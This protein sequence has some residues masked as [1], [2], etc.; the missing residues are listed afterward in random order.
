[1]LLQ[2][3][4]SFKQAFTSLKASKLRALLTML[5]IIIGVASVIIMLTTGNGAKGLI[6]SEIEDLGSNLIFVIAGGEGSNQVDSTSVNTFKNSDVDVLARKSGSNPLINVA[7]F[8]AMYR[9]Q[10]Q[11]DKRDEVGINVQGIDSVYFSM[12]NLNFE[13][14]KVWDAEED[15]AV[16]RLAVLGSKARDKIFG[17]GAQNLVGKKVKLG[18]Q[19]F[20]IVG[21]LEEK[22]SALGSLF[23]DDNAENVFVP[24]RT[25]QKVLLGTDDFVWGVYSQ[26][27]DKY[28]VEKA[29]VFIEETL[30]KRH[31]I[32]EGRKS[33]FQIQS[34]DQILGIFN[35][36]TSVFTVFLAAIAAISLIVGGVGIMNIM[37]VVV[38]E[39]TK[40]IGLRK[41]LGAKRSDVLIQFLVEAIMITGVGGL[42]GVV[43]GLLVSLAF[44]LL[45]GWDFVVDPFIILLAFGVSAIFGIVFGMY[46]ANKASKLDPI[47]A[48]R[49]I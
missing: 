5:G 33:D 21:V 19:S 39:R 6:V 41:A 29:K 16:K 25:A 20:Q 27:R 42:I 10:V 8:T 28:S 15:R 13:Q 43:F 3:S 46:P 32:K 30:R 7:A 40:E 44:A 22:S 34:Q 14:G 36:I 18:T 38:S 48:L 31:N 4:S 1:M 23:G 26:A 9:A 2:F 11:E 12:S 17:E 45:A 35:T 37:L 47:Q 24:T 49:S